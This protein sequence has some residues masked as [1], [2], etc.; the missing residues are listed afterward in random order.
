M[1]EGP[2]ASGKSKLAKQ[3]AEELGMMYFPEANLDMMYINSYGFDLRK[4]DLQVPE[5][6]RTFDVMDFLRDPKNIHVAKFQIEQYM[7]K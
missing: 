5:R 3:L 2:V 4:L 1:V 7:V 6:C